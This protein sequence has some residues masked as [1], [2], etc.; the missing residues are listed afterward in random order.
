MPL[1]VKWDGFSQNCKIKM[2]F[3]FEIQRKIKKMTMKMFI[4]LELFRALPLPSEVG[5]ASQ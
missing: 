4:F 3:R 1:F 5:D 2:T